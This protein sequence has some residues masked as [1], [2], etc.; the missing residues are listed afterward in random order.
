MEIAII[1]LA[2]FWIIG[3]GCY[4]ISHRERIQGLEDKVSQMSINMDKLLDSQRND[5]ARIHQ[6]ERELDV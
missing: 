5:R 2:I 6:L 4:I 3:I 1:I